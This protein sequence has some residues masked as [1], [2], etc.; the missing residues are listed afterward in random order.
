MSSRYIE[1]SILRRNWSLDYKQLLSHIIL[2]FCF[3]VLIF[4]FSWRADV[5]IFL[6]L[7]LPLRG[8]HEKIGVEVTQWWGR[9]RGC[10]LI[11]L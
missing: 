2:K 11:L 1:N 7:F 10:A 5:V 9:E 4:F 8:S 3:I 6:S